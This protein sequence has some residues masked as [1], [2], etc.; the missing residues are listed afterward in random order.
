MDDARANYI[1][2]KANKLFM[3]NFRKYRCTAKQKR[4]SMM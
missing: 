4:R 1:S 3:G 2:G